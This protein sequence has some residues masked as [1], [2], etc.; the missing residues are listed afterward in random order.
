MAAHN[1]V[2]FRIL[3]VSRDVQTLDNLNCAKRKLSLPAELGGLNVPFLE[4]DV[5]L[6]RYASFNATLANLIIDDK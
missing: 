3:G 1:T 4:L 6:P 5:E 2:L